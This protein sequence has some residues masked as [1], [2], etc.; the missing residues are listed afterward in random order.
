[1]EIKTLESCYMNYTRL[2][3]LLAAGEW[4]KADEET[5]FVMLVVTDRE[6]LGSLNIQ[7]IDNFPCEDL[8]IIDQLWGKYSNGRFGFSVQKRIYTSVGG[9]KQYDYQIWET[10]CNRVEWRKDNDW[11]Y[12]NDLTFDLKAPFAHLPAAFW[13]IGVR[14]LLYWGSGD[15]FGRIPFF[16]SRVETCYRNGS[17]TG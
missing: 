11:M 17:L 12:Y 8:K 3:D 14:G 13:G 4:R 15:G 9:T 7:S 6:E 2:R 5:A 10:F 1:M 16:F